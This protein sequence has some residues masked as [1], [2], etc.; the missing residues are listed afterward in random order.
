MCHSSHPHHRRYRHC[1]QPRTDRPESQVRLARFGPAEQE[2]RSAR[3]GASLLRPKP[4]TRERKMASF[5]MP[6]GFGRGS[7][8]VPQVRDS[9]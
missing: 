9:V 5:V 1:R 3:F 4:S 2:H 7:T 8:I 6:E